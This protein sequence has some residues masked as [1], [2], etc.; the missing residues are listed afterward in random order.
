MLLGM[1][2]RLLLNHSPLGFLAEKRQQADLALD[3]ALASL[4]FH[5]HALGAE[6]LVHLLEGAS[7]GLGDEEPHVEHTDGGH[8]A[9]E[10]KG[11]V[12]GCGDERRGGQA[13]R[14]VVQLEL[15]DHI[16]YS[17]GDRVNGTYPVAAAADTDSLGAH[18]QRE[19]FGHDDPCDGTWGVIS[20]RSDGDVCSGLPHA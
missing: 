1:L 20:M 10:D 18:A 15:S 12:V 2:N 5:R 11:T 8:A 6:Q 17:K 16:L 7:L 3:L 14:K 4:I 19:D 13:N 9:E